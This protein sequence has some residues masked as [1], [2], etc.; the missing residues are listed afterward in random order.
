MDDGRYSRNE[1]LF[2]AV[3]QAKIGATKVAVIGL[4]GLGTP[5]VQQLAYLGVLDYGLVDFDHVT[6]SSLNRLIGAITSDAVT[7]A[8][9][10][11]VAARL[12]RAVQSTATV[13]EVDGRIVDEAARRAV[14]RADVVFGCLDRDINRLELTEICARYARP[15]IDLATDVVNDG[16]PIYGG[17]V[18]V[19]DGTRCLVCLNV[20]DQAAVARDRM[21]PDQLAA[22]RRI[23]GV[24]ARALERTG[25]A[26]VSI[27]GVVASLAVT[28]F[29]AMVT[30]LRTPVPQLTYRA[31]KGAVRPSYDRPAPGCYYCTRLW[32]SNV[33]ST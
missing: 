8:S 22:D 11:G 31:D 6:E 19:A 13:V 16:E 2:G 9:K 5:T 23:Y 30:G 12:I 18:V 27:N 26:V 7:G 29:V 1:G 28:E 20:L 15:Y 32:G 14:A 17:R 21:T 4:G 33:D 3:G 10:V 24:D 25:P